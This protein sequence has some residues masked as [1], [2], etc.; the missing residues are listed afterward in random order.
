[1][2][3]GVPVPQQMGNGTYWSEAIFDPTELDR[4]LGGTVCVDDIGTLRQHRHATHN[5]DGGWTAQGNAPLSSRNLVEDGRRPV[6]L[7]RV[8]RRA[9]DVQQPETEARA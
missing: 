4:H 7:L 9:F 1:M 8:Q 2:T 5:L 3:R 6:Y